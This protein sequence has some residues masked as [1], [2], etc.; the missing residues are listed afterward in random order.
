MV[1]LLWSRDQTTVRAV[2]AHRFPV[3]REVPKSQQERSCPPFSW[4]KKVFQWLTI[5][6]TIN[7]WHYFNLL[8]RLKADLKEKWWGK[9]WKGVL[10]FLSQDNVLADKAHKTLD[11][12]KCYLLTLSWLTKLP[13]QRWQS[14]F[15][16]KKQELKCATP[17][18]KKIRND[19]DKNW[20][21]NFKPQ[22]GHHHKVWVQTKKN[23]TKF[24]YKLRKVEQNL[25]TN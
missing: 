6:Q 17:G 18:S 12:M 1:T 5:F 13:Q 4:I 16:D 15:P 22:P 21:Q 10:F 3:A 8:C 2:T 19:Q 14:H 23:G 9:I 24:E 25:S 20:K 7:A 11:V